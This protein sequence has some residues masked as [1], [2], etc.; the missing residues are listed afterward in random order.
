MML[1]LIQMILLV[2]LAFAAGGM[3]GLGFRRLASGP[4]KRRVRSAR[5]LPVDLGPGRPRKSVAVQTRDLSHMAILDLRPVLEAEA[6]RRRAG[7]VE[8][9]TVSVNESAPAPAIPTASMPAKTIALKPSAPRPDPASKLEKPARPALTERS[10]SYVNGHTHEPALGEQTFELL[11]AEV[12]SDGDFFDDTPVAPTVLNREMTLKLARAADPGPAAGGA[13][14]TLQSIMAAG[15]GLPPRLLS[16][17]ETGVADN[18]KL[19][20]GIG[21]SN[22]RELNALGIYHFSQI[23]EWGAPEVAWISNR[24]RFPKRIL[25]EDWIGQARALCAAAEVVS[26]A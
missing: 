15:E 5:T 24:I 21:A 23:A 7:P 20:N 8:G 25:S 3:L 19:I 11:S 16:A 6:D 2:A 22:E 18:L 12:A 9:F 10:P 14:F 17:P 1:L 26:G 13:P 4:T